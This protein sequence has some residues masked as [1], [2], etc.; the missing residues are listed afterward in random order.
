MVAPDAP[1]PLPPDTL[2]GSWLLLEFV[3]GGTYGR[4]YKAVPAH[5]PDAGPYALKLARL[6]DDPRFAREIEMLSR[7]QHPGVPSLHS[8][9]EFSDARGRSFPFLVMEFVFGHDLYEWGSRR[10]LSSRHVLRVLAQLA[11]T[12]EATHAL[13]VHRDVKGGNVRVGAD[14]KVSLL[15]FGS[16][17]LPEATSL[18]DSSIPPGTEAYRSHQ[19]LLF[20]YE[21][22]SPAQT[23]YRFHPADDLYALGV[24]LYRLVTGRYPPLAFVPRGFRPADP[25]LP[26]SQFANV[27]PKLES[28][29]LRLLS[30][31]PAARGTAAALAREA[32][33]AAASEGP[34]ADLLL[35][36]TVPSKPAPPPIR[37]QPRRA[38][39]LRWQARLFDAAVVLSLV[40]ISSLLSW[41]GNT[42]SRPPP[43]QEV[44]SPQSH[45]AASASVDEEDSAALGNTTLDSA[46]PPPEEGVHDSDQPVSAQVPDRPFNGQKR[47]PCDRGQVSIN[48]GCWVPVAGLES[49]CAQ[50][51]YYEWNGACY[52]P[53]MPNQR[54]P[55]STDP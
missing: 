3:G 41:G 42:L 19:L 15:D 18:T 45:S 35:A 52:V 20:R 51:W 37:P 23:R 10:R 40:A 16:C 28:L 21:H 30:Q 22:S 48:K 38:L 34:E 12:L 11:R 31:D 25:L 1:F 6:P 53:V 49:P 47:P 54:I 36:V 13:G 39:S 26:P 29:I 32:E 7:L 33:E 17:W 43:S 44:A 9:G 8:S 2:I 27:L 4:V 5:Q 14:G 55:T 24:L 50:A 46:S